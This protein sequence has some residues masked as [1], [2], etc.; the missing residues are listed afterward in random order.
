MTTEVT[1]SKKNKTKISLLHTHEAQT[2]FRETRVYGSFSQPVGRIANSGLQ[3][4]LN[5]PPRSRISSFAYNSKYLTLKNLLI[6]CKHSDLLLELCSDIK[7]R[8]FVHYKGTAL[9]CQ[10][11]ACSVKY[12]L[13]DRLHVFKTVIKVFIRYVYINSFN[14]FDAILLMGSSCS[15]LRRGIKGD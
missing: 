3:A 5:G 13:F 9:Y 8:K 2:Y 10:K 14:N 7:E 6:V 11:A 1:S 15:T 4:I 12:F